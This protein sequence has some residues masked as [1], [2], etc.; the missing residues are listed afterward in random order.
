MLTVYAPQKARG[1]GRAT[2]LPIV[3]LQRNTSRIERV[4]LF[5]LL[6]RRKVTGPSRSD[7]ICG[8][9]T[10]TELVSKLRAKLKSI[11]EVVQHNP[12]RSHT[13]KIIVSQKSMHVKIMWNSLWYQNIT[14]TTW[15]NIGTVVA[16][17]LLRGYT[18]PDFSGSLSSSM[19]CFIASLCC[20]KLFP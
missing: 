14:D 16:E 11:M 2:A 10:L 5:N 13:T 17:F 4:C 8:K 12:E 6:Y 7:Q 19:V 18:Q 9:G 15:I 3:C 1:L 20:W